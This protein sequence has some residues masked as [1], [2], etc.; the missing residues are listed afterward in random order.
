MGPFD[1]KVYEY[2]EFNK[3]LWFEV[4]LDL[5]KQTHSSNKDGGVQCQDIRDRGRTGVIR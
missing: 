5:L 3:L 2:S 4:E 1:M